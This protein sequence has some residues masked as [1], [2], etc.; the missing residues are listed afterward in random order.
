M[1]FFPAYYV[2]CA[3]FK[4]GPHKFGGGYKVSSC[5][6]FNQLKYLYNSTVEKKVPEVR[7]LLG[8]LP[9]I[10]EATG[11]PPVFVDGLQLEFDPRDDSFLI[12]WG[13]SEQQLIWIWQGQFWMC[14]D[15]PDPR[16][17]MRLLIELIEPLPSSFFGYKGFG[18]MTDRFLKLKTIQRKRKS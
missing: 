5:G 8:E 11:K 7:L 4:C 9:Q 13:V 18:P 3:A 15:Y 12:A 6:E 10:M 14:L 16:T 1:I 17:V 2:P